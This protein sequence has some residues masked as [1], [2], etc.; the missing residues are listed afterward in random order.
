MTQKITPGSSLAKALAMSTAIATVPTAIVW[1]AVGYWTVLNIGPALVIITF[2]GI[3]GAIFKG[4]F[5]NLVVEVGSEAVATSQ[6]A[7][8]DNSLHFGSPS[9]TKQC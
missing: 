9:Y 6:G 5:K 1:Y 8:I 4:L 2:G 7:P 3:A